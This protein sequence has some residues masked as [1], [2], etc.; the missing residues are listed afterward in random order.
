MAR[1]GQH[2][3]CLSALVAFPRLLS[4]PIYFRPQVK[5]S[6][7]EKPLEYLAGTLGCDLPKEDPLNS[8]GVWGIN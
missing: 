8:M 7:P 5:L 3:Q 2:G 4:S 6:R 1:Y